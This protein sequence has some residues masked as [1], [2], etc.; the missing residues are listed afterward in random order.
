[1][2]LAAAAHKE[3]H[4][5]KVGDHLQESEL[6]NL[7]SGL[8][9]L[10][11]AQV[12]YNRENL[13]DQVQVGFESSDVLVVL[14]Q[15]LLREL[16]EGVL[17]EPVGDLSQELEQSADD[18]QFKNGLHFLNT[19]ARQILEKPEDGLKQVQ[20]LTDVQFLEGHGEVQDEAF[21]S[22]EDEDGVQL[23]V[24]ARQLDFETQQNLL[25][26]LH[27]PGIVSHD[28]MEKFEDL[29]LSYS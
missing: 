4:L 12:S 24:R 13:D 22:H 17:T 28:I 14:E 27:C 18:V 21:L 11:N 1:M 26:L 7:S 10:L 16:S 25:K 20:V 5:E 19:D 9:L 23:I 6:R 29:L 3:G 8:R 2:K 15:L